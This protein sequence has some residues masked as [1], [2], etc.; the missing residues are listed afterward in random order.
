DEQPSPDLG[1]RE[2]VTRQA[3]DL[4]FLRCQSV[5]SATGPLPD[6]LAC[7]QQLATRPLS[8]GLRSKVSEHLV[9]RSQLH[10]SVDTS[11]L[12]T[13]PLAIDEPGAREVN[14]HPG[15]FEPIHRLGVERSGLGPSSEESPRT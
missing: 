2:S 10:T 9:S 7:R 1:V 11:V 13:Q 12:T 8:E 3:S 6:G 4:R 15:P 14:P 5:E